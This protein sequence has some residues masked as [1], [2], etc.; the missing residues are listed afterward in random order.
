MKYKP[1]DYQAHAIDYILNKP[2]AA[3]LLDMGLGK[4]V[5]TLTALTTMLTEQFTAVR[6]LVIAPLRVARDTWPEE[7]GKWDHLQGL[8]MA[9]MVGTAAER[10]RAL[11]QD[12]DVWVI[13]RE[14]LP[15][16]VKELAGE[17]PF[18][19][20]IIDEL[21]SFKSH[22]SQRFKALKQVRPH[23]RRIIG[24]TGTPAPNSL[25][26]LWAPFRLLDEGQRLG[27]HI[28][29]YRQRY[30]T[31]GRRNGHII[32]EWKLRDGADQEIHD[33]ISD[34]TLSMKAIDHLD[35]PP[36]TTI[37]RTVHLT[38]TTLALYRELRDE[39]VADLEDGE[40]V[41][42]DSAGVLAGKLQQL[43]S[44]AIY[45]DDGDYRVIHDEKLQALDDII[46]E[47]HGANVLVAFWYKHELARLRQRYPHG[48]LL[49]AD[50]D[51]TDWKQGRIQLGFIHPASAGHGLNLQSGGHILVWLT[52]PWSLELVEQ[53]N[54]RL[55][56]QGQKDPVT[57]VRILAA[58]T[59]DTRVVAALEA[60]DVTQ[61]ALIAAVKAELQGVAA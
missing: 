2:E 24:L 3:L 51:M 50:Q 25:L 27:T 14:N 45:T 53:T 21:S 11:H 48:R 4:T 12:A 41:I 37:D 49:D 19:T 6:P 34:I 58:P 13:N 15:W 31:P 60:K 57:I 35:M 8:T 39:M 28:G 16:L 40:T 9:V 22:S 20:V 56:R 26:D 42:A 10:R 55:H 59:I 1:H 18:D 23:I 29:H 46:D 36:V 38:G 43:A 54:G 33:A 61:S 47:A 32:Y 52:L 30:F 44:G 7:L 5:I 17:W